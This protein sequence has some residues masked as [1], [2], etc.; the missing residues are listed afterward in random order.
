MKLSTSTESR[1]TT[2]TP[3][4]WPFAL[5]RETAVLHGD[6]SGVKV[7]PVGRTQRR[8]IIWIEVPPDLPDREAD[9]RWLVN[10]LT[11]SAE[12]VRDHVPSQTRIR[13][14][15]WQTRFSRSGDSPSLSS[16][17]S[18]RAEGRLPLWATSGTV[19]VAG[20]M[21]SSPTLSPDRRTVALH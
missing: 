6:R 16:D 3:L 9:R 19:A 7:G 15:V 5:I 18:A 13:S 21:W 10:V 14:I 11:H 2:T 1:T 4:T 12:L 20:L 8:F 17:R